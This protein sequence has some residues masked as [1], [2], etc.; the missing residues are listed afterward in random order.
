MNKMAQFPKPSGFRLNG[1]KIHSKGSVFSYPFGK[2]EIVAWFSLVVVL[3]WAIYQQLLFD[4]N[5]L[6]L[7]SR[8]SSS[9]SLRYDTRYTMVGQDVTFMG[10][11]PLN[12]KPGSCFCN[13]KQGGGFCMCTPNLAID[14]VLTSGKDHIWLVRRKDTGQLANMGG[15]VE[16][17]ETVEHAIERELKEETGLDL[18][19]PPTLLGIYS[20]PRRDNR[21]H[22]VSAV[23]YV[24]IPTDASPKASDDVKDVERISLEE[25]EDH[26]FFAD[27]K[28]ILLD[29][30]S[31]ALGLKQDRH[32]GKD[33]NFDT[34][35]VRTT[36]KMQKRS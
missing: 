32:A 36:C 24:Q 8:G 7:Q 31:Y 4:S 10:G 22:T 2:R 17:G 19:S 15:F 14:V 3:S 35:I 33:E 20:D 27:H 13:D 18:G 6:Q 9:S 29:Y 21:R 28:T 11:H 23:Y 1:S 5:C 30:R 34:D 12:K 16:V 25:I 26:D